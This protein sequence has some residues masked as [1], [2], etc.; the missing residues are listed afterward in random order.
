[1]GKKPKSA[2]GKAATPKP[3][4]KTAAL[5][6][7]L[8]RKTGTSLAELSEATNWQPHSTRA[9]LTGLR[10]KGFA[11]MRKKQNGISRYHL[12]DKP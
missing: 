7:L 11:I 4:T 9:A 2:A 3:E 10:R 12:S 5:L 1:M 6:T 8:R